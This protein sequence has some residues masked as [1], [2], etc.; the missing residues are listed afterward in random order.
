MGLCW[1]RRDS[2]I[3]E[4]GVSFWFCWARSTHAPVYSP[5]LPS[6]LEELI[7]ELTVKVPEPHRGV[8]KNVS[9]SFFSSSHCSASLGP[10]SSHANW[11]EQ[12]PSG[13]GG[14]GVQGLSRINRS[15]GLWKGEGLCLCK[16][17][18]LGWGTYAHSK[19]FCELKKSQIGNLT[20]EPFTATF[21]KNEN[22]LGLALFLPSNCERLMAL[23]SGCPNPTYPVCVFHVVSD[24]RHK[25]L[26][27][28]TTCLLAWNT[29]SETIL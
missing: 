17:L 18:L 24:N 23:I 27:L 14:Q 1:G 19:H 29:C 3:L 6:Y 9:C 5:S 20:G 2:G 28:P 4:N 16:V 22:I 11:K 21:S 15:G 8:S 12:D 10:C 13:K 25:A 7:R 26:A